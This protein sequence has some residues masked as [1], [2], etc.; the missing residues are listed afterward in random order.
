MGLGAT[1]ANTAAN[2]GEVFSDSEEERDPEAKAR[3]QEF[4]GKM[5]QHYSK[6]AAIAMRQARELMEKEDAEADDSEEKDGGKVNGDGDVQMN[7]H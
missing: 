4:K 3:H 2:A 1:H 7:G 6:E 5:K